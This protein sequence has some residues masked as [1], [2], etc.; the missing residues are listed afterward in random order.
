[1]TTD[2]PSARG[3]HTVEP[4]TVERVVKKTS[5]LKPLLRR[6]LR[7]PA[8]LDTGEWPPKSAYVTDGQTLYRVTALLDV[9]AAAIVLEDCQSSLERLCTAAEARA[10]R[11]REVT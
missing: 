4:T 9:P 3:S 8:S 1:M 2:E 5:R 10:L 11:L 7:R 6:G